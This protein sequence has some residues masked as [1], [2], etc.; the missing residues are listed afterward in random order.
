MASNCGNKI[1]KQKIHYHLCCFHS[2]TRKTQQ[3]LLA[4]VNVNSAVD[5]DEKEGLKRALG[6]FWGE[7]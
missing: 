2:L 5:D 1:W 3:Q 7:N 4:V 6:D